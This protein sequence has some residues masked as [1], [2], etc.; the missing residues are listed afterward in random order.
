M[1]ASITQASEYG[2]LRFTPQ[3]GHHYHFVTGRLAETAL[4]DVVSEM[5]Q[6]YGF[7]FSVGVMPITVAALITPKWLVRHLAIPSNATHLVVPG[8]CD[9]G[10][11]KLEESVRIPVLV[12]PKDCREIPVFFGH[13][14]VHPDLSEH[15]IE[16]IA[17]INHV[18]R[19]SISEV[20]RIAEQMRDAGADRIDIGCD[21]TGRCHEIGD[22]ISAVCD[23]GCKVSIDSFDPQEV[24]DAVSKG[25]SLVLSVNSSNYEAAVDWGCEV[26]VIP[27][28]V[29]DLGSLHRSVDHLANR[30]V[31]MRLDS[32]LEPIGAGLMSSLARYA[33]VR[34]QYP[35]LPMM[36]GIGNVT[37]L[38][39]VDSAGVNFLLMAICQEL[40]IE[41]VLTTQVINWARS[42]VQEC[43]IARRLVHHSVS[44]GIP[45]K[46]LS[47]DLIMLRDGRLLDYPQEMFSE[48]AKTIK[49]HNYRLFAQNGQI[50]VVSSGVWLSDRDPF[51]LFERLLEDEHAANVDAGHA[52][53]LGYEM[54][55]AATAL[56]LGKQYEQDCALK[57]GML[58][59]EEDLHRLK[60]TSRSRGTEST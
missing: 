18:P 22:Y 28:S 7:E 9:V 2:M 57:W 20:V 58:T 47:E 60:R 19:K 4:R 21:P 8:Y 35:E 1:S 40:G 5:S 26:V 56:T 38:T 52:F 29:E 49:D 6:K 42:S 54:A 44:Q 43:D 39:D 51:R 11:E 25:A 27:D 31:A 32:I 34:E 48:L 46:R 24:S 13:N 41:S 45:P 37:E 30:G 14:A 12:G 17:E 53:Y 33:A 16:I 59:E 36:M 3:S 55:K 50:H 10:L 15:S 23:T